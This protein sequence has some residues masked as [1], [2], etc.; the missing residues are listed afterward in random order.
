MAQPEK[1]SDAKKVLALALL[2]GS[3]LAFP[4]LMV[5]VRAVTS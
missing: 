1:F 2:P 4:V 5:N 3:P